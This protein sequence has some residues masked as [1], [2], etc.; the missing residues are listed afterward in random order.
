MQGPGSCRP[1]ALKA[2]LAPAAQ[3]LSPRNLAARR[4]TLSLMHTLPALTPMPFLWP[5]WRRADGQSHPQPSLS[6]S[7]SHTF[8]SPLSIPLCPHVISVALS[9]SALP[10]ETGAPAFQWA[11]CSV[12]TELC[13][14]LGLGLGTGC[15]GGGQGAPS[16]GRH[17]L[18]PDP[19]PVPGPPCQAPRTPSDSSLHCGFDTVWKM[20]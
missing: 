14:R 16:P 18:A 8:M 4:G 11:L 2:G 12:N 7:L 5:F 9:P 17:R 20:H 3:L 1:D 13:V 6:M 19:H 15:R 10:G